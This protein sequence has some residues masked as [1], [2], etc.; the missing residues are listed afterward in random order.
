MVGA[1]VQD[2]LLFYGVE[3]SQCVGTLP[4]LAKFPDKAIFAVDFVIEAA[5]NMSIVC[6]PFA[7]L[8]QLPSSHST[9]RH[10][11]NISI[12]N[13]QL[14]LGI[15]FRIHILLQPNNIHILQIVILHPYLGIISLYEKQPRTRNK[16]LIVIHERF[17]IFEEKYFLGV[18][19][20]HCDFTVG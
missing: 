11:N 7:V 2:F 10:K 1:F 20:E 9:F 6:I 12:H 18:D 3:E 19:M 13:S 4:Y 17:K 16:C 8:G 14:I 15:H 5:T